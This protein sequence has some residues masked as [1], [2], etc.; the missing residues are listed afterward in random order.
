MDF[1]LR[2]LA[3]RGRYHQLGNDAI[4]LTTYPHSIVY[5]WGM[6]EVYGR[7]LGVEKRSDNVDDGH[8]DVRDYGKSKGSIAIARYL[9]AAGAVDGD[10][11]GYGLHQR[12]EN[13][14]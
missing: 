12:E 13:L 5:V 11:S 14:N 2:L 4:K 6:Y 8:E 1:N 9:V 3:L 7:M 10:T